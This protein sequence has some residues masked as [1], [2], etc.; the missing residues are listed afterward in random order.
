VTGLVT[1]IAL[2]REKTEMCGKFAGVGRL[3]AEAIFEGFY[4]VL[5]IA[6]KLFYI[7]SAKKAVKYNASCTY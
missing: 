5:F 3:D 4:S 6:T 7:T 1:I 2:K